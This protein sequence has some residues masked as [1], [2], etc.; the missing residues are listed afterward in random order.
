MADL[1]WCLG[2]SGRPATEQSAPA[3]FNELALNSGPRQKSEMNKSIRGLGT[4]QKDGQ[5]ALFTWQFLRRPPWRR[6]TGT[7]F[8]L[9]KRNP[10]GERH[11]TRE[12]FPGPGFAWRIR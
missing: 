4:T 12:G 9:S 11:D 2:L 7:P 6:G 1:K 8:I 10:E 3:V 5:S